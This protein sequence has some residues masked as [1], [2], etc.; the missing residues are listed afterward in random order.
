MARI[1]WAVV[2][3]AKAGCFPI[4]LLH[5]G[6]DCA[7]RFI[8]AGVRAA[9]DSLRWKVPESAFDLLDSIGVDWR[10]SSRWC[11][12]RCG[13]GPPEA[14]GLL[15]RCRDSTLVGGVHAEILCVAT[16]PADPDR[17]RC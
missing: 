10:G 15:V 17:L 12:L 7:G 14:T 5:D 8:V 1:D 2:T 16:R 13:A 11:E 6:I 9:T 4:A 3:H